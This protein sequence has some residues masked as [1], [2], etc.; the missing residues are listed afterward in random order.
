MPL[1][2]EDDRCADTRA[3]VTSHHCCI[4]CTTAAEILPHGHAA[5]AV[6]IVNE[7]RSESVQ[8]VFLRI[9]GE[10]FSIKRAASSKFHPVYQH[11]AIQIFQLKLLRQRGATSCAANPTTSLP[12]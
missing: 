8:S 11:P 12:S 5:S 2:A 1:F 3:A 10:R 7:L 4:F 9:F 6:L